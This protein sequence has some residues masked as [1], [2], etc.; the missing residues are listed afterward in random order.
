MKR[1]VMGTAILVSAFLLLACGAST[2]VRTMWTDDSFNQKETPFKKVLIM[3]VYQQQ[4]TG[5]AFEAEMKKQ[6]AAKGVDAGGSLDHFKPGTEITKDEL[7][8]FVENN[9]YDAVLVSKLTNSETKVDYH[10][11]YSYG[12]YGGYGGYYGSYRGGYGMY[13]S[14][15]YVST[16][17]IVNI[18]SN[19]FAVDGEKMVWVATSE[20]FD[21]SDV[22]SGINS[23]APAVV[24]ELVNKNY[25]V[26]NK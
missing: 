5:L 26:R 15:G 24:Y 4:S 18:E 22:M 11:G 23:F 6:F 1:F 21:P 25:F 16:Y 9:G 13:S 10:A 20:I 8:A 17:Q 3:G 12:G 2:T 14:P 7:T 19:L